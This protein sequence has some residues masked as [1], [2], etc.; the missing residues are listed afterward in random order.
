MASAAIECIPEFEV[1][2]PERHECVPVKNKEELDAESTVNRLTREEYER[3]QWC[4]QM[5]FYAYNLEPTEN[6]FTRIADKV[7]EY[8]YGVRP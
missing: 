7:Y 2:P 4:V 3:R 1:L 6:N 8:V 5:V